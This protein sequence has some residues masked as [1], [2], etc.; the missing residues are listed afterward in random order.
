MSIH[1][2]TGWLYDK[3]LTC[4]PYEPQGGQ[5]ELLWRLCEFIC[6]R[7]EREVFVLRGYAGT[8]K[9]SVMAALNGALGF[10]KYRTVLLA[11]TGRAAKVLSHYAGKPAS[12]IHKRLYRGDAL[13]PYSTGFFLA[14]NK[15][16]DT[17]FIVDEASM[18][19]A[20]NSQLLQHL[21]T[22]VYSSP[23]CSLILV[24]D[25]AQLPPVGE[26]LSLA[27]SEPALEAMGLTVRMFELEKPLRQ[28]SQSGIL[29]NATRLR[30]RMLKEPLP[31]ARLWPARFADVQVI[32]SEY[33]AEQIAESYSEVGQ[34]GTLVITRAN[35]RAAAFN[36][37]IRATVLYAEECIQR[38]ERLVVAKN[39][40]FWSAKIKELPFIANGEGA[41]LQR[42]HS[43]ESRYG[44]DWADVELLLPDSGIELECKLLLTCLDN[45]APS[46]PEGEYALLYQDISAELSA[47]GL[48]GT[49]HYRALRTNPYL[50]A[51]QAKYGYCLTCHKAQGGQWQ[52]VYIDL[53]GIPREGLHDLDF[54]RWLYTAV[55]RAVNRLYI[56]NPSIPLNKEPLEPLQ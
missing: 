20:K 2:D 46:L 12:T 17:L 7:G 40:Y 36:R 45:E 38:G 1:L 18:I 41:I 51:I 29:Y 31:E 49:D 43:R 9:T 47:R 27:M 13:D 39:N 4:F 52:H 25:V 22:H 8:G 42:I 24:G 19:A 16:R 44:H 28:A 5:D 30:R 37:A 48:T 26:S 50:N 53:A 54:H 56:I 3:A 21:V 10:T 35:W 32:T 11:P 14:E 15:D 55:T 33:L 34:D 23:G 6:T